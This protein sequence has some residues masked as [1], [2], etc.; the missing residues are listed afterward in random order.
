MGISSLT[1]VPPVR[2]RA[3]PAPLDYELIETATELF[4]AGSFLES[5]HKVFAHILPNSGGSG[6]NGGNG[7]NGDNGGSS[8]ATPIDLAKQATF[9]QGSSRVFAKV[10]DNL[11]FLSVPLVKLPSGGG[12]A[13]AALRYILTSI[14]SSGQLYQ[15]RLRGDDVHLEFTEKLSA[16][17]P[18][19]LLE[20]LR[21][22][23]IEADSHDDWMIGQF[24]ATALER[25]TIEPLDVDELA[26]VEL[27]WRA[28]WRDV[29]ELLKEAQRKRSMFFLNELTSFVISRVRFAMPPL[30]GNLGPRFS[31]SANTFN[32]VDVDP[33][34]REAALSKCIKEMKAISKEELAKSLGHTQYA[35]SPLAD[36]TPGRISGFFSPGDYME[37]IEG[38]KS[39]GRTMDAALALTGTYYYL[40]A[41]YAWP[42]EV[43][44][45]LKSGLLAAS[46]KP[47]REAANVL[48]AHAK[49][50]ADEYG[51]DDDDDD[52]EEE[53][54]EGADEEEEEDDGD[55]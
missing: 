16:L 6:G 19:K 54:E 9:T 51:G 28:H 41:N 47:W 39:G 31:A 20:V 46:E 27:L 10:D 52:E 49:T 50:V 26:R 42:A 30:G 25:A 7:G 38:A 45:A 13:V 55:E 12:G 17:H 40:L 4:D 5:V 29:E 11:F 1:Y 36:G 15:A 48:F 33:M 32:D 2:R 44:E 21:R 53:E 43:E 14:N 22:M 3:L 18:Q 8:N 34:K 35:I 23:P 37:Q 24:Q